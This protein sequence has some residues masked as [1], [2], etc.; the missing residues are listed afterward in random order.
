[1]VGPWSVGCGHFGPG[2]GAWVAGFRF[3]HIAAG[4]ERILR[5]N[6]LDQLGDT[7]GHKD[8]AVTEGDHRRVPPAIGHV[9]TLGPGIGATVKDTG[10]LDALKLNDPDR[11]A[12]NAGFRVVVGT[13]D[14]HDPPISQY[15]DVGT[16]QRTVVFRGVVSGVQQ[17]L[18]VGHAPLIGFHILNVDGDDRFRE[19]I[20]E[21]TFDGVTGRRP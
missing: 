6:R 14:G 4:V 10:V 17:A 21:E 19:R 13:T 16:E 7:A 15:N 1:M 5:V 18:T 8:I 20:A 2:A 3:H 11:E 9:T 12:I